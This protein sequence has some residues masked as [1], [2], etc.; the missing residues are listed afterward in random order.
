MYV[1]ICTNKECNEAGGH[2][3]EDTREFFQTQVSQKYN[4]I[5][6]QRIK[7]L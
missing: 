2:N 3:S 7:P 5:L 1:D 6:E 4:L